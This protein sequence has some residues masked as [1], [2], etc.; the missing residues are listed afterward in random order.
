MDSKQRY[1]REAG[2]ILA[3]IYEDFRDKGM[4]SIYLWGSVTRDDWRAD[5]SDIDA[6][7]IVDKT[8][9]LDARKVI[10]QRLK[11]RFPYDLKLGLQFYGVEEL[12]AGGTYT[13]LAKYQP[14][15]YLLLRFGDWIHVAGQ[16][17]QR[18]DFT[19]VDFTPAEARKH[20]LNQAI[21]ALKIVSGE[22]PIDQGRH[23]IGSMVED[24]VKG[25]LGALYWEAVE[26]GN[27]D[28]G[29]NYDTL[30]NI[31]SSKRAKLAERL[32]VIRQQK[33]H[34]PEAVL[35]LRAEIQEL[36]VS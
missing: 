6:I 21:R 4:L 10:N 1:I 7:A 27:T 34:T 5:I 24:V 32:V 11:D 13:L 23:G 2:I 29:L 14:A 30:P 19:A 17:Y 22:L 28:E 20:Q 15:G 31:V 16:R 8:I 25:T 9:D 12:N 3:E 18:S 26:S 35:P 36:A 33:L